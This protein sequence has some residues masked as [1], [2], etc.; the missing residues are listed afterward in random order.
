MIIDVN[1]SLGPYPFRSLPHHAPAEMARLMERSG[2]ARAAVA[3]TPAVF[4]RDTHRGNEELRAAIRP[5]GDRFV[6]VATI[7]PGYAGWERDLT[8][9]VEAWRWKAVAL[10]PEFHGYALNDAKGRAALARIAAL[11]VPVVLTQRLEDRRQR[12]AWDRAED[13]TQPALI[14]AARAHPA[15]KFL[16]VNWLGLDGAK[17][18]EAGLRGRVLI[19]LARLQVV[20]RK[21]VP[22]LLDTL[23]PDAVAFGSHAPFDYVGPS[24][25]KLDNLRLTRPDAY[26]AVA[27]RNAAAFLGLE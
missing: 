1:A 11:G 25:V 22:R 17:L 26:A 6:P 2:I 9:A 7:N 20:F 24:L 15:L 27:S 23:G 4:Y 19:D 13:L 8:E 3:W 10:A 14:E 18:A 21:E 12:H 16:L 5:Y